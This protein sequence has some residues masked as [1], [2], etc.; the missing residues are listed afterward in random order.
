MST[1]AADIR[2]GAL[3]LKKRERLALLMDLWASLGVD[4]EPVSDAEREF[5]QR[6]LEQHRANPQ[7][8]IPWEEAKT[9]LR[10]GKR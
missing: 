3:R 1:T 2:R 9:R 6:A 4:D 8:L 5:A 7:D 10:S